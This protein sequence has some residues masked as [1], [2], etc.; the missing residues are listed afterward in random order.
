MYSFTR[1]RKNISVEEKFLWINFLNIFLYCWV[2]SSQALGVLYR[3]ARTSPIS[4]ILKGQRWN[5][6]N[7]SRGLNPPK[8]GLN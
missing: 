6:K 1:I 3:L 2:I 5:L 8:P 4:P 7:L